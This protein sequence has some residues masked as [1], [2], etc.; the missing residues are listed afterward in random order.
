MVGCQWK[1]DGYRIKSED[2]ETLDP[3]EQQHLALNTDYTTSAT[4][5]SYYFTIIAKVFLLHIAINQ[6]YV[7]L[8]ECWPEWNLIGFL[9]LIARAIS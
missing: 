6:I 9:G 8:D 7:N 2:Q 1:S 3:F 5:E 4:C